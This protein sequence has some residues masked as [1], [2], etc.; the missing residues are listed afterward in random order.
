[1]PFPDTAKTAKENSIVRKLVRPNF[2]R[3]AKEYFVLYPSRK[4]MISR[5]T[6]KTIQYVI[7]QCKKDEKTSIVAQQ[8]RVSQRRIQQLYSEFRRTGTVPVLQKPGRKPV[9]IT[10]AD[11]SMVLEEHK[12]DPAGVLHTAKKLRKNHDISYDLTYRIVLS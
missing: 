12:R 6:Q 8:M 1:M 4:P 7:T 5:L 3:S 11:V 9:I 10:D 2:K